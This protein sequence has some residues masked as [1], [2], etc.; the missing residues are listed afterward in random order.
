MAAWVSDGD[1]V[2]AP[3]KGR[4]VPCKVSIAAGNMAFIE[5][6]VLGIRRWAEVDKLERIPQGDLPMPDLF[7]P[8]G[9]RG[10]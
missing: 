5:N 9:P 3:N 6:E 4:M 1:A 8:T 7:R 2:L 10:V